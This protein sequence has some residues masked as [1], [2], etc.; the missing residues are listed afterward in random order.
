M[1]EDLFVF[2]KERNAREALGFY[3]AYL[4]IIFVSATLMGAALQSNFEEGLIAGP[5]F[6]IVACTALSFII[7][8]KKNQ[9]K[10]YGLVLIALLSGICASFLGALL[11][12]IPVSYLTTKIDLTEG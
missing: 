10:N 6:A 5:R 11:W 12:L 3:L 2:E 4:L 8:Y 1:F 9:L 7:L